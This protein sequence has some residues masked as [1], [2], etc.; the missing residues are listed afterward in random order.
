M[1]FE[2]PSDKG[3]LRIMVERVLYIHGDK[4]VPWKMLGVKVEKGLGF[5]FSTRVYEENPI[6]NILYK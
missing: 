6:S 5:C 2:K 3:L 1:F 4:H